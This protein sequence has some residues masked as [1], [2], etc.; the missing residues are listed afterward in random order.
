MLSCIL[1]S[2]SVAS[3]A[4]HALNSKGLSQAAVMTYSDRFQSLMSRAHDSGVQEEENQ[5]HAEAKK[6]SRR[7]GGPVEKTPASK[8]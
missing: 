8:Y 6:G 7:K 1:E 3:Q 4:F 2:N 5:K